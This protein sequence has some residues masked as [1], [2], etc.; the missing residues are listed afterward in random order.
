MTGGWSSGN[1][2]LAMIIPN[3][4][5]LFGSLIKRTILYSFRRLITLFLDWLNSA[6][7]SSAT[8]TSIIDVEF[9]DSVAEPEKF[10][11]KI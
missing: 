8:A 9:A 5:V 10:V 4:L 2:F 7:S 3:S 6:S 1:F 11:I